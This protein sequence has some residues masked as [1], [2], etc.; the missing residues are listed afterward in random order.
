MQNVLTL[1]DNKAVEGEIS[2]LI[3]DAKNSE[4]DISNDELDDR[5]SLIMSA[6]SSRAFIREF[7]KLLSDK[8]MGPISIF[9]PM[10]VD[11]G[12][13]YIGTRLGADSLLPFLRCAVASALQQFA[14]LNQ[15][16]NR[17][18]I[19]SFNS[20]IT[21]LFVAEAAKRSSFSANW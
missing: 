3:E 16:S 20:R 7:G 13:T 2:Q 19:V 11:G 17:D 9:I 14:R 1:I 8:D 21:K 18:E 12:I 6:Y 5:L 4:L 10:L 15:D